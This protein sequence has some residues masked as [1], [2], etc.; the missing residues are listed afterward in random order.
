MPVVAK[1][2]TIGYVTGKT[3]YCMIRKDS[4]GYLLNDADGAFANAPADPYILLTEH[5]TLKGMYTLVE[6]RVAWADG[7][8][9]VAVY[10]TTGSPS[11]A[12][13][14]LIGLS[15]AT[16]SDD[17]LTGTGTNVLDEDL[18][19]HTITGTTGAVLNVFATQYGIVT[20]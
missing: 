15:E 18:S 6:S 11:P 20:P 3:V 7:I 8:Y 1:T 9:T 17:Y 16:I 2:I 13:D 12:A 19:I 5:A 10:S 4:N 14:S